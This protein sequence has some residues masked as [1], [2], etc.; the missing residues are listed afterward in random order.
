MLLVKTPTR[1]T[2]LEILQGLQDGSLGR[3]EVV[4]WQRAVKNQTERVPLSVADGYWYFVSM[5]LLEAKLFD[6]GEERWF[7]RDCD[8]EEYR[9][10]IQRIA[11]TDRIGSIRRLRA[12]QLEPGAAR[13]PLAT[14]HHPRYADFG[15]LAAVRG[16]FEERGDLVE[17]L[18]LAYDDAI[19]LIVRQ[20]D[21]QIEEAMVL[22]TDRDQDKVQAFMAELELETPVHFVLS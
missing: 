11:P 2:M 1:E 10:D 8:L 20:F 9:R 22:G 14:F 16:T 13:W 5:A 21:D 17:H 3:S 7:L 18:H 19:Y 12:H 6:A 4:S 15:G